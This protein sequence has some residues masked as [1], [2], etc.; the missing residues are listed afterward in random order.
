MTQVLQLLVIAGSLVGLV[1]Y[2]LIRDKQEHPRQ[3]DAQ[4]SIYFPEHR[5]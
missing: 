3:E 5:R 2:G 4:G 1:I